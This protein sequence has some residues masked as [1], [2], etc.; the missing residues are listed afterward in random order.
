M[1]ILRRHVVVAGRGPVPDLPALVRGLE[2][3]RDR[4][5]ARH[6]RAARPPRVAWR[7]RHLAQPDDALAERRL[8]LRRRR[9]PRRPSRPRHVGGHGR[10]GGRGRPARHP[11]PAGPGPEPHQRPPPV[12]PGCARGRPASR[13]L[14]V[15]RRAQQLAVEL[16][17]LRVVAGRGLRPVL[18]QQL[19]AHAARPQLVERG[20]P[21]GVRRRAAVL[22]RARHRRLPD[23]R[24]PR[25]RQG[26]RAARRP[27]GDAGRPPEG[28]RARHAPGVLHE[29]AR[30]ARRPQALAARSRTR[31]GSWWGRPTSSSSTS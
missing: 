23:R 9:L 29:P 8:G 1:R 19:P 7:R 17:R 21:R 4:R 2:R 6:R 30:G 13:L 22:V 3:R 28:A 24:L 16:R 10:A 14:R 20:R 5:P 27:G 31:T 15:D 12:V 11:R 25:D 18:P 26:P